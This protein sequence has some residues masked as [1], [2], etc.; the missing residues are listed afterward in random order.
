M[1][2]PG[3]GKPPWEGWVGVLGPSHGVWSSRLLVLGTRSRDSDWKGLV[4]VGAD[5]MLGLLDAKAH[6]MAML[7]GTPR[8]QDWP[9]LVWALGH[10]CRPYVTCGH[11][12]G[13]KRLAPKGPGWTITARPPIPRGDL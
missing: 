8:P 10:P 5:T 9:L 12:P 11:C 4:L 6:G 7:R 13:P 2:L 1:E 3:R